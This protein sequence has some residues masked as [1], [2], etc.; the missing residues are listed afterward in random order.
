MEEIKNSEP[1]FEEMTEI[2]AKELKSLLI[3]FVK[4]YSKKEETVS[5]KDWLN[6][7]FKEE[8]P[9]LTDA[10]AEQ[11]A[12]DTVDSIR[13]YDEN[14]NSLN[15]T[16]ARGTSKEQWLADKIAKASAGVSV[17][18]H[19]EYL[20][21]IDNALANANAQM[22]RT[23]TTNSG[24]ISQS[25]NL[26]GFIAE[27]HHVN[28]FN[29]NAALNRSKFFA[30]VK[31]PE[32]GE[33]YG[34]NSFDIVIRDASNP[35]ATPVHQYQVKYGADAQATIQLLREHGEVTKYPNQQIV[36]PPEQVAEVQ[37]AFPGKT[38][39]SQIG[40]TD[41]V[42]LTSD[43]LTKEQAKELQLKTQSESTIPSTD[44]NSFK[45]KDLALQIGRNAGMV[46]LQAAAIT[47]GFSLASQVIK[48]EG[49]P[50]EETVE[51]ALKTGA[52]A[53]VKAAV[54]GALKV[55]VEKGLIRLIP[56]GTPIGIIANIVCVSIENIKILSKVATGE[57][58]MS[59]AMD[60]MGRTSVAMVYGLGWGTVGASV[61]AAA[62]A[63]IPVVGPV[64]GGL[65]GGMVGYMAGSKFGEA[66]YGGI[67]AIA[68][69]VVSACKSGWNTS[70]SIG[71][72]LKRAIVY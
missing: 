3:K 26:D 29:A 33:T 8:L 19:G 62:L 32:S 72:R 11:M 45:T 36:V 27:Q 49:I 61:G 20:S 60:R 55:G 70:K 52:D 13:E 69:I 46:G 39:V 42:P 16:A 64:V 50:V 66:V 2:E 21:S 51:V 35:K 9:D 63:W 30:E 6:A 41:K 56:K 37:K 4:S 22:M 14:L 34:K 18:Q 10:Q 38:V 12:V 5:D 31:V 7:Q 40:G 68:K 54:T 44:W 23:V 48:G 58:T 71:S 1:Q 15:E 25:V 53:G 17:I 67:K 28:S 59:Q 57:L 47:T 24:E 65:V 43:A